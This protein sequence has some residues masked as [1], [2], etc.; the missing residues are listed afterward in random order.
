MRA[1]CTTQDL[2]LC[3]RVTLVR[4]SLIYRAPE[5]FPRIVFASKFICVIMA[6]SAHHSQASKGDQEAH[7]VKCEFV[8]LRYW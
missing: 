2:C 4:S 7:V 8:S 5:A 6:T 3:C 1:R